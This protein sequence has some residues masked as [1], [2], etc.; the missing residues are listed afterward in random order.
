M[1]WGVGLRLTDF[2]RSPRRLTQDPLYPRPTGSHWRD[3]AR[4]PRKPQVA[5]QAPDRPGGR[6]HRGSGGPRG[7]AGA[8]GR[9]RGELPPRPGRHS[10]TGHPREGARAPHSLGPQGLP[11][12]GEALSRNFR[13][14]SGLFLGTPPPSKAGWDS[15]GRHELG[16]PVPGSS[17][18]IQIK[19]PRRR[20]SCKPSGVP[21]AGRRL[22]RRAPHFRLRSLLLGPSG[23]RGAVT[24]V[25]RRRKCRTRRISGCF[26]RSRS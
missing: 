21:G 16:K 6:S 10:S 22:A 13:A 14:G 9:V 26:G 1:F 15:G 18:F 4:A 20:R 8:G 17:T 11:G 7:G 5:A 23:R 19:Q 2:G 25:G 24:A 3:V 12:R